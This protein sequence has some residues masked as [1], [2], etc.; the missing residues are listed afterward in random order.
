[1]DMGRGEEKKKH[2]EEKMGDIADGP[3]AKNLCSQ[4]RGPGFHS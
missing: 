4:S 2:K 1:M 3:V